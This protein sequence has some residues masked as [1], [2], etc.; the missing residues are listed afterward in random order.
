MERQGYQKGRGLGPKLQG[1]SHPLVLPSNEKKL[2]LGFECQPGDPK[3]QE[4]AQVPTFVLSHVLQ[5]DSMVA[6]LGTVAEG[7]V[8]ALIKETQSDDLLRN[9]EAEPIVNVW[10]CK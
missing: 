3:M 2:G 1:A 5:P 9:W 4:P 8:S 6:T 10:R 7:G